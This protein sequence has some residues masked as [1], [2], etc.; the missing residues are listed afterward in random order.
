[1]QDTKDFNYFSSIKDDILL[2]Y[3]EIKKVTHK[4]IFNKILKHTN[5]TN[6]VIRKLI[7]NASKQIRSLFKKYLQERIQL[8]QFKSA[9]TIV[10]R[11]LS[12][13]NYFN[14]KTYKSI[15]LLDTLNKILKFII[16][17]RLRSVVEIYDT[18][19]NIQIKVRKYKS[20]NTILQLITKKIYTI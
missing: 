5:Y 13:K 3:R 17:K 10:L 9:I 7:N 4:I 1:M 14:V 19:L 16:L 12:K 18:I 15:V 2:I 8:I 20:T 11:K 6:R